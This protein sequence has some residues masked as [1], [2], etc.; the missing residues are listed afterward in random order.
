MAKKKSH[1]QANAV[2]NAERKQQKAEARRHADEQKYLTKIRREGDFLKQLRIDLSS[3]TLRRKEFEVYLVDLRKPVAA[4]LEAISADTEEPMEQQRRQGLELVLTSIDELAV[5]I[6]N[7]KP[8]LLELAAGVGRAEDMTTKAEQLPAA[9]ELMETF[10]GL[11]MQMEQKYIPRIQQIQQ[12]YQMLV[13]PSGMQLPPDMSMVEGMPEGVSVMAPVNPDGSM[14]EAAKPEEVQ[15]VAAGD[16]EI[17]V[18]PEFQ[19]EEAADECGDMQGPG[20][21]SDEPQN[22]TFDPAT[23]QEEVKRTPAQ[24]QGTDITDAQVGQSLANA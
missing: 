14:P 9:M 17:K 1:R 3:I 16:V 15:L 8:M 10:Q 5:E 7:F 11:A 19:P 22:M 13:M 4:R 23:A 6:T 20:T 24:P 2:K 18:S 21:P 12:S